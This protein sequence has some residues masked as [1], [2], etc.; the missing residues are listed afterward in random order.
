MS[1]STIW[2]ELSEICQFNKK[3][4]KKLFL[5]YQK[6]DFGSTE[7]LVGGMKT[8]TKVNRTVWKNLEI[9]YFYFSGKDCTLT[10]SCTWSKTELK[11]RSF[12]FNIL[13][14]KT[15]FITFLKQPAFA[16][17]KTKIYC[18]LPRVHCFI[19]LIFFLCS[20]L[21]IYFRVKIEN[22]TDMY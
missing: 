20:Y 12:L 9:I 1:P 6:I 3:K 5:Y 14:P 21:R 15:C 4:K 22:S 13:L 10:F 7:I 16:A 19:F 18:F 2:N 17:I 11:I 8:W